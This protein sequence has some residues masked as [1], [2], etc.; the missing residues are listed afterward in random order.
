MTFKREI[1]KRL[2]EHNTMSSEERTLLTR[3]REAIRSLD[4]DAEVIL[5]GSRA[6][7]TAQADSDYDLLILVNGAMDPQVE[8]RFRQRLFPIELETGKVLTIIA[9]SQSEWN[10]PL[11]RVMLFHQN[12]ENDGVVL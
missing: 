5:Y 9:F 2:E 6:R 4:P 11:Y 10:T 3:C 7:G 8:A 12:V 1:M